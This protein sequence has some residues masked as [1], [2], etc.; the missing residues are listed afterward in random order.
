MKKITKKELREYVRPGIATDIT[1]L[2]FDEA[3]E[4]RRSHNLATLAM[5]Y[6]TYGMT[7]A[8]LSDESGVMYAITARNST[9]FQ[10]V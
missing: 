9:L 3:E 1:A 7:G 5:S 8:L 4:L 2:R 10:F 6:G